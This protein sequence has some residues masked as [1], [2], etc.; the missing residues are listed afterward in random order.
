MSLAEAQVSES[1][2]AESANASLQPDPIVQSTS[3]WVESGVLDKGAIQNV[4]G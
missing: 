1:A 2:S 3:W 4:Q